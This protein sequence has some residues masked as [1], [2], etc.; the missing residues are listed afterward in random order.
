[1]KIKIF[2]SF[3]PAVFFIL[4]ACTATY[5]QDCT[6]LLKSDPPGAE[7]WKDDYFIGYTPRIL[8]YTATAADTDLGYLRLPPLTVKKKGFKPYRL[9]ETLDIEEGFDWEGTVLLERLSR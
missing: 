7:I 9:E 4:S 5:H 2:Y 3:L 6:F 1:M 8:R